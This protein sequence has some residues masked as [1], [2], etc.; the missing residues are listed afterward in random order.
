VF[1]SFVESIQAPRNS[2]HRDSKLSDTF[3]CAMRAILRAISI[4]I[5]DSVGDGRGEEAALISFVHRSDGPKIN[6]DGFTRRPAAA[7]TMAPPPTRMVWLRAK[8]LQILARPVLIPVTVGGFGLWYGTYNLTSQG[9]ALIG[10][11]VLGSPKQPTPS[12]TKMIASGCGVTTGI[13]S[14]YIAKLLY[15]SQWVSPVATFQYRGVQDIVPLLKNSA[16]SIKQYPVMRVYSLVLF[17]GVVSG[18][19]KTIF[20]RVFLSEID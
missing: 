10:N 9:T 17:S 5:P 7:T 18:V 14:W 13:A 15:P 11:T 4:G 1:L 8:L 3:G 19:S 20:E 6:N 2:F 12:S 16:E